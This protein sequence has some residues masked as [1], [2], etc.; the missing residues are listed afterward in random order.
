MKLAALAPWWDQGTRW[1]ADRSARERALLAALGGMALAALLIVAVVRPI[2]A[3][4]ARAA[5]DIRTADMLALR[6]RGAGPG[7][8]AALRGR[9]SP[10]AIVSQSAAAAGLTIARIEPEGGRLRVAFADAPFD[11]V[12]R[13]IATIEQTG[14]VRVGEARIDRGLSVP[15]SVASSFLISG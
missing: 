7:R 8:G 15:G 6:L 4:R 1:W 5:A 9:G 12:L 3:E 2:Q 10:A 11:A 13:W 14:A